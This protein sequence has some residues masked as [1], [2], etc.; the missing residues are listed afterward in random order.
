MM[1]VMEVQD[2]QSIKICIQYGPLIAY[3]IA[4]D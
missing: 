2:I 3:K 1:P 4:N